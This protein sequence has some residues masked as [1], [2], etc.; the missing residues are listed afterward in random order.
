MQGKI[1][2]KISP[3][4]A[5]KVALSETVPAALHFDKPAPGQEMRR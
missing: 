2:L 1:L 4:I 5:R 3:T